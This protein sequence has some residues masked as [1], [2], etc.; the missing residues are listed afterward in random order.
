MPKVRK[1]RVKKRF[2]VIMSF[3]ALMIC[4]SFVKII[5][6]LFGGT[7]VVPVMEADYSVPEPSSDTKVVNVI[8]LDAGHGGHDVGAESILGTYEKDINL[9]IVQ[10][11]GKLLENQ[12]Y[13]IVYVRTADEA[14]GKNQEEDL[15]ARCNIS[16]SAGADIFVSVHCNFDKRSQNSKGF[17]LWCMG[18]NQ[19]GEKLAESLRKYMSDI[20]YTRDRGIKYESERGL[21]V[22]KNT[23]ATAVL[24]ELGFLSNKEDSAFLQ[25]D[26]GQTKCAEALAKG[27]EEYI[28]KNF[29]KE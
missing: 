24:A 5:S 22:L 26:E 10:K 3:L 12:G 19:A 21:Y 25:S 23:N 27:I 15:K 9:K 14:K 11:A 20:G 17:E 8:C 18:P 2:Y 29:S 16:N 6:G 13:K 7:D 1:I 4:I 28:E